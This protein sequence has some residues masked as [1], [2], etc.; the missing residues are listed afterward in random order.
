MHKETTG[1]EG[2]GQEIEKRIKSNTGERGL[3]LDL[4]RD[5]H[6]LP[7]PFWENAIDNVRRACGDQRDWIHYWHW[8]RF[9]H[10]HLKSANSDGLRGC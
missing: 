7:G 6:L 9:N 8:P 1:L 3:E 5:I 10:D 2:M 4:S